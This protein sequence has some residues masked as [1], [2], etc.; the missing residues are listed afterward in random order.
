MQQRRRV[1]HRFAAVLAERA[2]GMRRAPTES[3][4][5]LWRELSGGKLGVAFR[6]Q[7]PIDRFIVDFLAPQVA[8]VVEVDG[9]CHAGHKAADARR[10]CKL[11]RLG[12][13]VLRL[14]AELVLR[15]SSE[16]VRR[17]RQEL[18]QRRWDPKA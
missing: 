6:R 11:E 14:E 16:A 9:S 3:E 8:L 1:R 17:V 15:R 5:A 2:H 4:A 7:V 12:F 10:Q 13:R 18:R